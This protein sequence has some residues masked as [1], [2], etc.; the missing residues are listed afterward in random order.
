ME[1]AKA[2]NI[3]YGFCQALHG[4]ESA[5]AAFRAQYGR[6]ET[7]RNVVLGIVGDAM[8]R[9]RPAALCGNCRDILREDF[10]DSNLEIARG[11]P[12]RGEVLVVPLKYYLFEDYDR[13]LIDGELPPA[14]LTVKGEL[15]RARTGLL[16][17]FHEGRCLENDVYSPGDVHPRRRYYAGIATMSGNYY[18]AHDV[19]ADYHPI[20]AL[21]DAVRQAR[22]SADADIKAVYV[23]GRSDGSEPPDVMYKDRQHLLELN[24]QGELVADREIDPPVYLGT[25]CE[26]TVRNIWRTSVK[27]WLP[28]PFTARNF[29]NLEEIAAKFKGFDRL[30]TV[31]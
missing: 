30:R 18:G 17:A 27:E 23:V 2:G 29:T 11:N 15:R 20:Y 12:D 14:V 13:L 22:R 26:D 3:E 16:D 7:R 1:G 4:E 6:S 5:V 25:F 31:L 24:L 28:F 9:G 10:R 21:R 19:M 8:E